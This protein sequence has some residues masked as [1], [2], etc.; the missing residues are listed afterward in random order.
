M[1]LHVRLLLGAPAPQ[2][3]REW[4]DY[5]FGKSLQKAFGNLGHQLDL[6]VAPPKP[7]QKATHAVR[8][9]MSPVD[10]E[11]VLRGKIPYRPR[12]SRPFVLWVISNPSTLTPGE[13]KRADHICMASSVYA[14]ELR[15]EGYPA[16]YLPQCTDPS[17]FDPGRATESEP[18]PVVFVGNRRLY[19]PRPVVDYALRAEVPLKIWGAKWNGTAAEHCLVDQYVPN[20]NLGAV[21]ASAEVVLN[22][23]TEDMLARHFLSNRVYDVLASGRPIMSEPMN[24]LPKDVEELMTFYHDYSD[25]EK[26]LEALRAET[27]EERVYRKEKARTIAENHSFDA[28]ARELVQIIESL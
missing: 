1:G 6:H 25:F 15:S 9:T 2:G 16:T 5:S 24:G 12:T 10:A 28:R 4:G 26:K 13:L 27:T 23:H 18:L 20:E 22:D 3:G 7:V 19:A 17:L 21:Y 11:I 14:A 8:R